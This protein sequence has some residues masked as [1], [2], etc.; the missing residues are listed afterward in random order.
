MAAKDVMAVLI[1][2][3]LDHMMETDAAVSGG[4]GP[5]AEWRLYCNSAHEHGTVQ[6]G[7]SLYGY[8]TITVTLGS[9]Q[10]VR[11]AAYVNDATRVFT[12][13][14]AWHVIGTLRHYFDWVTSAFTNYVP[15]TLTPATFNMAASGYKLT[16]THIDINIGTVTGAT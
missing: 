2:A 11:Y 6:P 4:D 5:Q 7:N 1:A 13:D 9:S 3:G 12:A 15:F 10:K 8:G 14:A 16:I